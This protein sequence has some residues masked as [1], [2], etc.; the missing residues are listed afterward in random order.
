[1]VDRYADQIEG[2]ISCYDR[3]VL[4]G[5]LPTLRYAK[6]MVSHL[7]K[8]DIRI[9]DYS[10][11]FAEPLRNEIRTKA[12]QLAEQNGLEIEFVH[13]SGFC[14]EKRIAKLLEE[15]GKH[16][17]LVHIFS[18]MEKCPAYKPWR[19]KKSGRTFLRGYE[20][21][22]LHYYF[23][24]IDEWLGLCFLKVATWCPFET[25]FYFNGHNVLAT[26]LD[27]KGIAYEQV[28][29]AL[30]RISDFEKAQELSDNLD[31]RKLH[32]RLDHYV[33]LC[34]PVIEER[35]GLSLHWSLD[36]VEYAT[37]II[38][39]SQEDLASLYEELTR[40]AIHAVKAD[41]IATFFGRNLNLSSKDDVASR[42]NTRI[43]GTRIKHQMGPVWIKM[44]DKF[45]IIL[46]IEVTACDVSLFRHHRRVVHR[47]GTSS[48]ML[49]PVRK[50]IYSLGDLRQLLVAAN[51][52]YLGFISA[53]KEP[54]AGKKI[55]DKVSRPCTERGRTYK[56]FNFF[57]VVDQQ[58]FEVLLRGEHTI[59]GFRNRDIRR[60]LSGVSPGQASRVLKRLRLHG[61]V[62][63]VGRTYKYYLTKLGRHVMVSGL[64][65]KEM[66]LMPELACST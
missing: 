38:F 33:R 13:R 52:R 57:S 22:C 25:R 47:N 6:G 58:L 30:V 29:N 37:D 66:H 45:G 26:R 16:P 32:R 7:Y 12:E 8:Q 3:V 2:V 61:L 9:F 50:T 34:C 15:R 44:Y 27:S 39:R 56:G 48:Y 36:Q 20:G 18:G 60:H 23:Y 11:E 1:M 63:R 28:D 17:G 43:E 10:K 19:D 24:F 42:F 31:I 35:L 41:N 51:R 53:F 54:S 46:R 55:L 4:R 40:T 5:T 49:A 59:S 14:K 64:K 21:Q 62:K 65:L